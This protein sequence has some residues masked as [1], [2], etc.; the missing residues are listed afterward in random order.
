MC[1]KWAVKE[2]PSPKAVQFEPSLENLGQ[3]HAQDN[4]HQ[5]LNIILVNCVAFLRGLFVGT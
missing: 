4:D 5:N 3:W 1:R 2:A